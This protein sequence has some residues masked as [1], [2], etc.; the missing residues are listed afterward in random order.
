MGV[1]PLQPGPSRIVLSG[2][3]RDVLY[4][5]PPSTGPMSVA[6]FPLMSASEPQHALGPRGSSTAP[7][8]SRVIDVLSK[9]RVAD[10]TRLVLLSLP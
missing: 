1:E 8:L 10:S 4:H 6:T 3:D 2:L 9:P 5:T 7:S